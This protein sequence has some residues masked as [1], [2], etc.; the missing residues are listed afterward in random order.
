MV[1][2]LT[3]LVGLT[4]IDVRYVSLDF[5][6][7]ISIKIGVLCMNRLVLIVL[8]LAL[9]GCSTVGPR[10]ISSSRP[11]YNIAVQQTN[12]QELLL[13]LVRIRYRDTTYFTSVERIA[14]TQEFNQGVSGTGLETQTNNTLVNAAGA[15]ASTVSGLLTRT[16]SLT[17][18]F[19]LNEKPTVF[20]APLEGEK[21]V[22]QMM[23][24]MN[25]DVLLLL[26]RSGWSIDRIFAL[27]VHELNGLRNAPTAA[28]ITPGREPEFR[29]FREAVRLLRILQR[30]QLLDL[31]K[32]HNKDGIELRFAHAASQREESKRLKQLLR[33][34]PERD[35]FRLI[36]ASEQPNPE[37]IAISTRPV[38]SA[39][40]YLSQGID[41]PEADYASGV[42]KQTFKADGTPFDWQELLT[43]LFRVRSSGAEPANA[44]IVVNYA[45]QYFFIPRDDLETK[46]TFV[47]LTQLMAL[48][49]AAAPAGPA[50]SFSFG[51]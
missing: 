48:H 37:S 17:P 44:S 30:E 31:V 39:L 46:A 28:G 25:V 3:T 5:K 27:G 12:D 51:K 33:L 40:N 19:S 41:I 2:S 8:T 34:N 43:G 13:N 9:A 50:M 36:T 29:D 42:A 21:F 7:Q 4:K 23:T 35:A 26:A 1:Q 15:S 18:S 10:A 49:S 24:P 6:Y 22:R 11:A 38:M 47:L 16:F 45:G 32:P 14:A 20:Y